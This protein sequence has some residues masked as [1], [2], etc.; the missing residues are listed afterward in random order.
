MGYTA[1]YELRVASALSWMTERG[2]PRRIK[3][4]SYWSEPI[5]SAELHGSAEWRTRN[6]MRLGFRP[7]TSSVCYLI[8]ILL[9]S[10]WYCFVWYDMFFEDHR[11]T[12]PFQG[13]FC[14]DVESLYRRFFIDQWSSLYCGNEAR[15]RSQ[16]QKL[17]ASRFGSRQLS[18]TKLSIHGTNFEDGPNLQKSH[19]LPLHTSSCL[20][21]YCMVRSHKWHYGYMHEHLLFHITTASYT[22]ACGERHNITESK[23][24]T[25]YCTCWKSGSPDQQL[26]SSAILFEEIGKIIPCS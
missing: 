8:F 21:H 23:L 16:L 1:Y 13:L 6:T 18:S 17:Q 26:K 4:A 12:T 2:A 9:V 14:Y 19:F 11:E 15:H 22:T 10:F 25:N 20:Q 5:E 24:S 3:S 7:W